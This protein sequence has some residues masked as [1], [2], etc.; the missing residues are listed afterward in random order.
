MHAPVN[1]LVANWAYM[2]AASLAWSLKAWAA[3]L[4]PISTR[5]RDPHVLK[6]Q[7]LLRMVFRGFVDRVLRIPAQIVRTGRRVICRVIGHCAEIDLFMR[8]L[9]GV[10]LAPS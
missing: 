3:L 8:L 7:T 6:Q 10:D 2:V 1:T 9:D 4:I 5:W